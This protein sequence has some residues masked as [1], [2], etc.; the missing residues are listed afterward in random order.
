M[1]AQ[2][3]MCTDTALSLALMASDLSFPIAGK[4]H[5]FQLHVVK[6]SILPNSRQRFVDMALDMDAS[7]LLFIDSDMT[8]PPDTA[9]HLL[10]HNKDVVAANCVTRG[11]PCNPTA[12][13][14]PNVVV[15]SQGQAG[16]EKVWRVGTGVMLISV[17][18]LQKLPRPC[19][20]P[21]WNA[22]QEAYVGEDWAFAEELE[23]AGVDIWVDHD[24]SQH[25]GHIGSYTHT[26]EDVEVEESP[27]I[28]PHG[29]MLV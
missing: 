27:L 21:K 23:K 20:T 7:H 28:V 11:F 15:T 3:M 10:A 9:R 16:L 12:R 19:F 5:V 8:F 26:F 1:P 24:L 14:Y 17:A 13:N 18:A 29:K 4:S 2:A 25:V 6:S 22:E